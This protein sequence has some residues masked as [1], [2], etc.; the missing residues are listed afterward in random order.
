MA[1]NISRDDTTDPT[2]PKLVAQIDNG[3]LQAIDNVISKWGFRDETSM[4]RFIFAVMLQAK[5]NIM[6]VGNENGIVSPLRP[7]DNLLNRQPPAEN[8]DGEPTQQ[9]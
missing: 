8:N 3:D 1:I 6:Y 5:D 2:R 4:L 9:Q 7:A